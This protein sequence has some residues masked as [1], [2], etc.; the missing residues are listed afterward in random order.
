MDSAH[1]E[2]ESLLSVHFVFFIQ[3]IIVI[4]CRLVQHFGMVVG[5]RFDKVTRRIVNV[6]DETSHLEESN[7]DNVSVAVETICVYTTL[8]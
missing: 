8:E 1:I 2:P 4:I 6:G 5:L 3:H 7:I